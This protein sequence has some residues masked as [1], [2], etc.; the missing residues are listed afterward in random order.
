MKTAADVRMEEKQDMIRLT[1]RLAQYVQKVRQLGAGDSN[2][3]VFLDTLKSIEDEVRKIKAMYES[4]LDKLR[5]QLDA[6]NKKKNE[7]LSEAEKYKRAADELN[8]RFRAESAKNGNLINDINCL[9]KRLAEMERELANARSSSNGTASQLATANNALAKEAANAQKLA[10]ELNQEKAKNKQ[11][12]DTVSAL[13][14][15]IDFGDNMQSEQL[16]DTANR[17]EQSKKIIADLEARARSLEKQN[18]ALPEMIEQMR[19]KTAAEIQ[20][21]KA[22]TEAANNKSN[23]AIKRQLD[24]QMND[25]Q[26]L[27]AS[28]DALSAENGNLLAK[29]RMLE[30]QIKELNNQKAV[31]EDL[32]NQERGRAAEQI[33]A[34]ERKLQDMTE[35]LLARIKEVD[36][37]RDI[38]VSLRAEI[39]AMRVLLEDEERR[40]MSR[41]GQAGGRSCRLDSPSGKCNQTQDRTTCLSARAQ[42]GGTPNTKNM[43]LG[44]KYDNPRTEYQFAYSKP[45]P[46][47]VRSSSKNGLPKLDKDCAMHGSPK[48]NTCMQNSD[49][50][51]GHIRRSLPQVY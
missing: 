44:S 38:Q 32:L 43:T 7:A 51:N 18:A 39:E 25:L 48:T 17:L 14:H 11:L 36:S 28:N 37:N 22:D 50:K 42:C 33:R 9:Q 12:Q 21:Y 29:I 4:E 45:G 23:A 1:D 10:N 15:K 24:D 2:S 34:L 6:A 35:N 3:A 19:Q 5:Q 46:V 26:K 8:D 27:R 40:L 16:K 41:S 20:K 31:L 47:W 30:A 13:Q 49:V